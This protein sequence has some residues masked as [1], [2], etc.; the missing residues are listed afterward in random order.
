MAHATFTFSIAANWDAEADRVKDL[1]DGLQRGQQLPTCRHKCLITFHHWF[2]CNNWKHIDC[3]TCG[4]W[5]SLAVHCFMHLEDT[6]DLIV[7]GGGVYGTPRTF[8]GRLVERLSERYVKA[9]NFNIPEMWWRLQLEK[10]RKIDQRVVIRR[11]AISRCSSRVTSEVDSLSSD[12][13]PIGMTT[14]AIDAM[15]RSFERRF[16]EQELEAIRT[17]EDEYCDDDLDWRAEWRRQRELRKAARAL[18][19]MD[20]WQ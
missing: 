17:F 7:R 19:T 20:E 12:D 4:R 2:Q 13:E 5:A 18:R 3:L 1:Y 10:Q 8:V 11:E 9:R 14:G 6:P 16:Y 15:V